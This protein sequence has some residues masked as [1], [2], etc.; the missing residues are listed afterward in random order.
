[1]T[2]VFLRLTLLIFIVAATVVAQEPLYTL[3]VNV[4]WVT[5]DVTVTDPAG[6]CVSDLT[7]NDFQVYENGVPQTINAFAP[8]SMP[9]NILLL[10]D[11]SGSTEHKWQFMLRAAAGFIENLRPQDRVAIDSFDF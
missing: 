9:Y 11:R 1:M 7:R 5:V 3:Q 8:V 6:R 4:P 2:R 10:F